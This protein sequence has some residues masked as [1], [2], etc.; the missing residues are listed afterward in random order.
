MNKR[1]LMDFVDLGRA[2]SNLSFLVV[3]EGRRDLDICGH[4]LP[5]TLSFRVPHS[6]KCMPSFLEQYTVY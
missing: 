4:R 5:N 2:L 1:F 6:V 3:F